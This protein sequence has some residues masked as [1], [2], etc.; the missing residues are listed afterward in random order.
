M[1]CRSTK[2]SYGYRCSGS[3][4]TDCA[5]PYYCTYDST[6]GTYRCK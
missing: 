6:Y 2:L 5:S 3:S 1:Y 4:S